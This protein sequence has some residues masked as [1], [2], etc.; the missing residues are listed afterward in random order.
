MTL[1]LQHK[2]SVE[3]CIFDSLSEVQIDGLYKC[4]ACHRESKARV[5]HDIVK[6]PQFMLLHIK[7]FDS[8]FKKISSTTRYPASL[9]MEQ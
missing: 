6:L 4:E 5:K 2:S 9:D 3:K 7:R 1:S 8:I